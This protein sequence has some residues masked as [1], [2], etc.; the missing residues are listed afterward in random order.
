MW[1]WGPVAAAADAALGIFREAKNLTHCC[2]VVGFHAALKVPT[3]RDYPRSARLLV[4]Y[5]IHTPGK[6]ADTRM[7]RFSPIE[8]HFPT[9]FSSM[10]PRYTEYLSQVYGSEIKAEFEQKKEQETLRNRFDPRV[11]EKRLVGW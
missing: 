10:P 2:F 1:L 6:P 9:L 7:Q 4:A 8:L 3:W 11:I 5:V